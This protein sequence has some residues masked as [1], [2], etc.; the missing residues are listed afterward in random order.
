MLT[1]EVEFSDVRKALP[2]HVRRHFCHLYASGHGF[3]TGVGEC[4]YLINEYC[5]LRDM[6][7]YIREVGTAITENQVLR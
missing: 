3:I 5:P 7:S 1:K 6:A 4:Y 2:L